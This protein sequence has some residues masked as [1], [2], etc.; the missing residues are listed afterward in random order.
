MA[1]RASSLA[2]SKSVD[3][4][5]NN[6]YPSLSLLFSFFI[7]GESYPHQFQDYILLRPSGCKM[8]K[9]LRLLL[10]IYVKG[11]DCPYMNHMYTITL[12]WSGV[13][14]LQ[15]VG[16]ILTLKKNYYSFCNPHLRTYLLT[17]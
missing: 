7:L 15:P 3:G 2:E 11:F 5:V 12:S 14:K 6:M 4:I 13:G 1:L 8:R 10:S 9:S 16:Q 17:F